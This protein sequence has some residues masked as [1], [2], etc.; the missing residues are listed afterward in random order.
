MR[1]SLLLLLALAPGL[2]ACSPASTTPAPASPAVVAVAPAPAAA[3]EEAPAPEK[4][5][6]PSPPTGYVEMS[7]VAVVPTPN[8]GAAVLLGETG[9]RLVVPIYVGG[10]EAHS[11]TLRM[12]KE[13]PERPL[14]HDLLDSVMRELGAELVK[15]QVDE[16]RDEVFIGS[17]FLRCEGKL[18]EI[19]SRP[20]DA[21]ALAM[22]NGVPIF[23]AQDVVDRAGEESPEVPH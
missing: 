14:T 19:D 12:N 20:S 15:V 21:I 9:K 13:R 8:R 4:A 2:A 10:T 17:V 7:V 5:R 22:G 23:V 3:A 6:R 11:I 18:I 16:L 1:R